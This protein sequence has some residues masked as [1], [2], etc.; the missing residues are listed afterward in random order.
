VSLRFEFECGLGLDWTSS[1]IRQNHCEKLEELKQM[2]RTWA[3]ARSKASPV[4]LTRF[5]Q[6]AQFTK[7]YILMN[8]VEVVLLLVFRCN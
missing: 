3:I 2:W 7:S 4:L 5:S 1:T 6:I 8:E